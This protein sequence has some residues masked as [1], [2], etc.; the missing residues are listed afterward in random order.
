MITMAVPPRPRQAEQS[1]RGVSVHLARLDNSHS[2]L[3]R[4]RI[5]LMLCGCPIG[6][7][8]LS[9]TACWGEIARELPG[10]LH[11]RSDSMLKKRHLGMF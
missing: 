8:R 7:V 4:V 2:W 10:T 6:H 1:L 5:P 11:G 3:L 9:I